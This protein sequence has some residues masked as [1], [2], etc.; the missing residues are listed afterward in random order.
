MADSAEAA[1]AP[2][3]PWLLTAAIVLADQAAK[4]LAAAHLKPSGYIPVIP[5]LFGLC[6]VENPGAAWGMLAGR[7][8]FLIAFS[9]AV[10]AVFLWKW[11]QMFGGLR[12]GH[13][14]LAALSG[15]ILGNL[16]DR[17]RLGYV[18]DFL[19]FHWRR[20]HFPA[21]NVA[22]SAICCSVIALIIMQWIGERDAGKKQTD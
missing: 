4:H 22:D 1:A 20:S 10:F 3:V 6:Y 13:L 16:I 2:R 5:G 15:G 8:V 9:A 12:G 11:R 19:D 21:F 17:I 18:I 7:Q 14:I